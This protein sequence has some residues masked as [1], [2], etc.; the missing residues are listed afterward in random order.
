[1]EGINSIE[2]LAPA[3]LN[4]FLH[5]LGKRSDGYHNLQTLFQFITIY[6]KLWFELRHDGKIVIDQPMPDQ[7]NLIYQAAVKL[8]Q[9]S[10]CK[11]G[12]NIKLQKNIPMGAGLGGG[13]SDAASTLLALN[14]LWQINTQKKQLAELGL[15]LGADVPIFIHGEP[16]FAEGVG[17]ILTPAPS[18]ANWY[19]V[20]TPSCHVSTAEVFTHHD[21]IRNGNYVE[22]KRAESKQLNYEYI[23]NLTRNDC[24]PLVTKLYPEVKEALEWLNQY[25]QARM[26]GTGSAIFASFQNKKRAEQVAQQLPQQWQSFVVHN[27]N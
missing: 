17:D 9:H 24:Q 15:S 2:K 1:M 21:L 7:D 22:I 14:E 5:I 13:S 12:A 26:T 10:N 27:T 4:L 20:V 16:A 3:K 6:D 18:I 25:S 8:Q 11:L 19:L 23:F